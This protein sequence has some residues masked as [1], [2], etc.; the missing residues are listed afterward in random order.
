MPNLHL[1]LS[2]RDAGADLDPAQ[3]CGPVRQSMSAGPGAASP[4]LCSITYSCS[5]QDTGATG[6]E[7]GQGRLFRE[8][9]GG[10]GSA[11]GRPLSPEFEHPLSNTR[12]PVSSA[13]DPLP[14]I[15]SS[16]FFLQA[17]H[18]LP[19]EAWRAHSGSPS[20]SQRLAL[21]NA[22][23]VGSEA[24]PLHASHL[25]VLK[26]CASVTEVEAAFQ[27]ERERYPKTTPPLGGSGCA[28]TDPC[29]PPC[30]GRPGRRGGGCSEPGVGAQNDGLAP[31]TSVPFLDQKCELRLFRLR[32]PGR[33]ER[34]PVGA[35]A[36]GS[37][38]FT[39][40]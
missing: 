26:A 1:L 34:E 21:G 14:R 28:Q 6:K 8:G 10:S 16:F 27:K 25:Q 32:A 13:T 39:R 3:A 24:S 4:R 15:L 5:R 19:P 36:A 18:G 7:R 2:P 31:P 30:T 17:G 11:L 33:G 37:C 23:N 29:H 20:F 9:G 35:A 38:L 22:L 40:S 12:N